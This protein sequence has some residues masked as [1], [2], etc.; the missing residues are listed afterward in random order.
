MTYP[1]KWFTTSSPFSVTLASWFFVLGFGVFGDNRQ[2]S[3][4][5][6]GHLT[7]SSSDSRLCWLKSFPV[8]LHTLVRF[9]HQH[10]EGKIFWFHFPTLEFPSVHMF[11]NDASLE[12]S[13]V[14]GVF[15]KKTL[16]VKFSFFGL[17]TR[18]EIETSTWYLSYVASLTWIEKFKSKCYFY[19]MIHHIQ[20]KKS[21]CVEH[22]CFCEPKN[23]IHVWKIPVWNFARWNICTV[24][25]QQDIWFLQVPTGQVDSCPQQGKPVSPRIGAAAVGKGPE[26]Q[27]NTAARLNW[28][29][30]KGNVL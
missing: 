25:V 4:E 7:R 1:V 22:L 23:N 15:K 27:M 29:H 26:D 19:F 11:C 13:H 21:G 10:L 17:V 5:A 2:Q 24:R 8:Y 20:K 6:K 28:R 3:H 14:I 18:F 12:M 30:K 16:K 9:H